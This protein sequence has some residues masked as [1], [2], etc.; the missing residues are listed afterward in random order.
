MSLAERDN[1]TV[2][3][4]VE[5]V[6]PYLHQAA[7][8]VVPL[9][10]GSGTRLKL[11]QAMSAGCAIVSTRVGAMGLNVQN[12]REMLLAD[13]ADTFAR[14]VMTL[15]ENP[16]KREQLAQAGYEFVRANFDWSMIVPR[17]L[18]VYEKLIPY[19]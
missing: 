3:G 13:D 17:L 2:T 10:V 4:F 19:G 6:L 8:F 14:Q 15:L 5:D 1:I 11:L 18:A 12:G 9:R 16:E 7:V